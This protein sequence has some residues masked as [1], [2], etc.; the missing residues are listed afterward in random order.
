MSATDNPLKRKF[1]EYKDPDYP[2]PSTE[3]KKH[4]HSPS[5]A[6]NADGKTVKLRSI[7]KR[8][9][10]EELNRKESELNAIEHKLAQ[11]KRLLQRI[12]YAIVSSFYSKRKLE[13]SE[14]MLQDE[15]LQSANNGNQQ[16]STTLA[17]EQK[18]IHPSLKKLLGKK[19][20]DYSEILKI[21][22]PRQAA[23]T[24]KTSLSEKLR[25]KKDE[26]NKLSIDSA[27]LVWKT[28]ENTVLRY[29]LYYI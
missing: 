17:S 21:R 16:I 3:I 19:P 22:P 14:Q 24:A 4:K 5:K 8:E 11:S 13:F 23:T 10:Q 6:L 29:I 20:I 27:A 28:E 12:R 9:F 25:S 26:R 2:R 15:A 18:S 1:E 7:I